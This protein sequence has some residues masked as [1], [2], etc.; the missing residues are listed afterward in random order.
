[1]MN[2]YLTLTDDF[3]EILQ[4]DKPIKMLKLSTV[5]SKTNGNTYKIINYDK[6]QLNDDN[7][8]TAGLFRSVILNKD[9]KLVSF[10]PPKSI[11]TG[12]FI[13]KYPEINENIIAEEFVEGTM[14]NVFWDPSVGLWEFATRNTVGATSKFFKSAE[15]LT[16]RDMFL[17]A[18]AKNNLI[19]DS[20]NRNYCYSFV[21]QH[22]KNRI[23]VPFLEPQLYLVAVYTV[24]SDN[25]QIELCPPNI[26]Q[27]C[28][29]NTTVKIP[30]TYQEKT[31]SEL[32]NKYASAE[33]D[34]KVLGVML[35]N[36]VT[37]ERAK[38]RNPVYEE[39]RCLR[40]NQPK[41][42]FQY[43]TLRRERKVKDFL[44]FYPENK[45]EFTL[46]RDQVHLFTEALFINYVSCYIKKEKTLK[47]YPEQFRTHM[48]NLHKTY[49]EDLKD[50]NLYVNI[51]IV[52]NYINDIAPAKLMYSLNFH[53]RK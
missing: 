6:S 34:Y 21:L 4:Y 32:I 19:I 38:I 3:G 10:S 48:F 33:T 14:I 22:P 29:T 53:M 44:N 37:G 35:H 9:I 13:Q 51:S 2:Y 5:Q 12:T 43:L 11:K 39:V 1:M 25:Y 28:L 42:Q 17:E 47:E 40:G 7:I 30:Q 18:V 31:Y 16:F 27:E 8:S 49:L 50:K 26:L 24:Y 23:V 46:F 52:I 15:S 41:L 45:K 20:L 36:K